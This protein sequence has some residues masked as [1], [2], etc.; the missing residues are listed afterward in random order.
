MWLLG[1]FPT[2]LWEILFPPRGLSYL[3]ISTWI[4]FSTN[5]VGMTLKENISQFPLPFL[6]FLLPAFLFVPP[7]LPSTKEGLRWGTE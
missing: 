1:K 3:C 4:Q 5:E 2:M 6:S 7:V